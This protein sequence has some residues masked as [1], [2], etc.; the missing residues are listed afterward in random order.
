MAMEC[1]EA[2]V[3]LGITPIYYGVIPTP[4]LA[5][6]SIKSQI[7]SIM[8]TGSHIPFDRNGLKFYSPE[9]E[10][11]K[12]D[13]SNILNIDILFDE[14][15]TFTMLD[16]SCDAA[17]D[18]I[19]RYSSLFESNFLLGRKIG[20]YEHSSAG[21]DLYAKV[22]SLLGAEVVSL[23]RSNDFVPIDTEAVSEHDINKAKQWSRLYDFDM[24]FSTDGDG[25]RPL[26]FNEKGEWIRGDILGLL[27]A[28][29]LQIEALAIPINCNTGIDKCERFSR[30]KYTKIGSPFVISEFFSLKKDHNRVAGFEANGGFLLGSDITFDESVLTALPTRDAL[31]PALMLFSTLG[32]RK[33]SSLV[34][35]L[36]KRFTHSDRIENFPAD[37]SNV[38]I[39]LG[40]SE[41]QVLI[42]EIC[43]IDMSVKNVNT[44]DGLRI[45]LENDSVI[46]FRPS[47]N[48][49]ELRCYAESDT[50]E[51]A[52]S[53]VNDSLKRVLYS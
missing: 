25:D 36:P 53:L 14:I 24:I 6:K 9:G 5:L 7:P 27:C 47:G 41:P 49:P 35:T 40:V 33:I 12:S 43:K 22:F 4:A 52:V 23:G 20:I 16:A 51:L 18:Y 3:Q 39:R 46:H 26:V 44:V 11:T 17:N 38:I 48:A 19:S 13:E 8:I 28:D 30:I 42:S 10:I 2:A 21:R 1:A 50:F 32:T 29:A 37:K 34:E 45:T 15:T 31:L